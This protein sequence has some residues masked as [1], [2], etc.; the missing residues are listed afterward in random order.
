MPETTPQLYGF[1]RSSASWRVRLALKW[2]GVAYESFCVD[3]VKTEQKSEKYLAMNPNGKVPSFVTKE[4]EIIYQSM[5][6]LEYLEEVY[7]ERPLLPK[8]PLERA[9]VRLICQLV[10]CDI[11]P[12]QNPS[13]VAAVGGSDLTKRLEWAQRVIG[14][15]FIALEKKLESTAGIYCVGNQVTMAD[16]CVV[17]MVHNAEKFK[18]DLTPF[19]LIT[20]INNTLMAL[21]EFQQ[22][23]P[24]SQSDC[25]EEL[26]TH[27]ETS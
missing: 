7:P 25:P 16:F 27:T 24:F 18:L 11:Q 13:V 1:Y 5:A 21:E 2:K 8:H 4:G 20:R 10:S 9:Q 15:G 19:P 23:H 14:S 26:K 3:L 17:P 6:I 22:T 12:L